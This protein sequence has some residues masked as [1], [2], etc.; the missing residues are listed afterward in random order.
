MFDIAFI[1]TNAY[2]GR[3]G[4]ENN[5][6]E[7]YNRKGGDWSINAIAALLGNMQ[8]ESTINPGIWENLE[9]YVGG[10]GLVQWT[11]YTKFTQW[12]IDAYG[13]TLDDAINDPISQLTRIQYEA[14]NGLQWFTNPEAPIKDPP[15]TLAA[16]LKSNLAPSTLANYF[17]WF[18]E[19]PAV[20]I[21]PNRAKQAE[22]WYTFL[23]GL[24]PPKPPGGFGR[25]MPIW[26][27]LRKL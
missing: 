7:I 13:G 21:Q 8:T 17:L 11:P 5:A 16:F 15:I 3:S 18:Y 14:D 4:Q 10:F 9:P 24:P 22:E 12:H 20:T 19:H 26:Y 1:S 2:L 6:T 25:G 23:T 27:A